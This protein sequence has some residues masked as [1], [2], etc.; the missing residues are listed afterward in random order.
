MTRT[1]SMI[2]LVTGLLSL[3]ACTSTVM[4]ANDG[5]D[6]E[7]MDS[8]DERV[9][10]ESLLSITS[11]TTTLNLLSSHNIEDLRNWLVNNDVPD[12]AKLENCLEGNPFCERAKHMLSTSGVTYQMVQSN[13]TNARPKIVMNHE[14]VNI[15]DCYK[16][17]QSGTF[18]FGC[19]MST[20]ILQGIT[21][22]RQLVTPKI[23]GMSDASKGISDL[24]GYYN[25]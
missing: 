16:Y 1:K 25:K 2:M 19:A 20:N 6:G 11:E 14:S 15:K 24:K 17:Q 5:N 8:I 21:D 13:D 22:K 10:P 12:Y 3:S 4:T 18:N 7:P 23:S 9:T